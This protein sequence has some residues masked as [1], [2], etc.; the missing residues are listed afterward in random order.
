MK[1]SEDM[2]IPT[3][4]EVR[5]GL[6]PPLGLVAG[7]S[8][9]VWRAVG[10]MVRVLGRT[11][12]GRMLLVLGGRLAG[13]AIVRLGLFGVTPGRDAPEVAE[14]WMRV[15]AGMGCRFEVASAS[16]EEVVVRML[17]CPAGLCAKDGREV[18]EAGME[19]DRTVV[20]MLGGRLEIGETF[21]TGADFCEERVVVTRQGG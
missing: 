5:A 12:L 4:D 11:A 21:A 1:G 13:R 9:L 19:A 10:P 17:E 20:A 8:D 16:E 15:L 14:S 18:C 3:P 2:R 6:P 7:N